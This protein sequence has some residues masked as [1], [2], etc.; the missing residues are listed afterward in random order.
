M[1][2]LFDRAAQHFRAAQQR[3]LTAL[4]ALESPRSQAR[5]LLAQP[6]DWA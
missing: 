2:E 5:L 1:T 4:E 6:V 3:V